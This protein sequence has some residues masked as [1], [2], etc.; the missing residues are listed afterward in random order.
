MALPVPPEFRAWA[1]FA[2]EYPRNVVH[3]Y[4]GYEARTLQRP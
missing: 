4:P 1:A 2:T 3:L